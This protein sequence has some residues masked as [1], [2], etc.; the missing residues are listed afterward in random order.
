[1]NLP[2]I[3]GLVITSLVAGALTSILGYYTPFMIASSVLMAIG[4]GLMS[5]FQTDTN[6]A[7]WIG[8][9]AMFG[10][11]VGFG[12]QQTIMAAQTV[13]PLADVPIGT[14]AMFFVQLL[15]GALFIAV[16]QNVWTTRLVEGL[17]SAVPDLNPMIVLSTGATN[18]K[19]V[20]DPK[21]LPGVLFAYNE[22][23]VNTF[24]VTVAMAS[25]SIFG[26]MGMEWRS[27]KGKK[28]EVMA[29]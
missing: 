10:F 26:S 14:A 17:Q 8:Y 19:T 3:M 23:L 11:G 4:S 18:L 24:Y 6:H 13:L 25:L 9:Q 7:M 21:F 2:M 1:M 20:I 29:A 12:M 16:A 22:A 5:T 15:G 27:V 28:V